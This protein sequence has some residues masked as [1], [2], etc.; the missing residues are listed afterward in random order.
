MPAGGDFQQRRGLMRFH[1][2]KSL[3][4]ESTDTKDQ[5][6]HMIGIAAVLLIDLESEISLATQERDGIDDTQAATLKFT[7]DGKPDCIV[8][9]HPWHEAQKIHAGGFTGNFD[10]RNSRPCRHLLFVW[11]SR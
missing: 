5:H 11:K 8:R 3:A 10:L 2:I 9:L 6:P 1:A 4:Q 7:L